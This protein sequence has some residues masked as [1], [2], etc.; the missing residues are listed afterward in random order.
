MGLDPWDWAQSVQITQK[1]PGLETLVSK[2]HNKVSIE[3][4]TAA[5]T[6]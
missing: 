2:G 1:F 6:A 4:G 5:T 3:L